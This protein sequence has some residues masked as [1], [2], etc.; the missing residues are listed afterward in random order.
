MNEPWRVAI[1]RDD[2]SS[3]HVSGDLNVPLEME[4][5]TYLYFVVLFMAVRVM[6]VCKGRG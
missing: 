1:H 3:A 2:R 6:V 5:N 4:I